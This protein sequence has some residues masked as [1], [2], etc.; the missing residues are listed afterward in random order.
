LKRLTLG[1]DKRLLKSADFKAVLAHKLRFSDRLLVL[2]VAPNQT[3]SVRLG[4]SVGKSVGNAAVR[5]RIKRLLREAF[6]QSQQK[7]PDALDCVLMLATTP[8]K[9]PKQNPASITFQQVQSSLLALLA[10]AKKKIAP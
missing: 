5:N 6:R 10:K 4:V 1:R 9:S 2:Y 8:A 7:I 3:G